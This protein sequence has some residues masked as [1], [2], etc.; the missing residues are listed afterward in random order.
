MKR[1]L[2][3]K[4]KEI[5]LKRMVLFIPKHLYYIPLEARPNL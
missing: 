2:R 1:F 5:E 4:H 3:Y